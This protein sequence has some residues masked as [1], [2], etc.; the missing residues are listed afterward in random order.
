MLK[1]LRTTFIAVLFA[2]PLIGY[3]LPTFGQTDPQSQVFVIFF[4]ADGAEVDANGRG[5]IQTATAAWR[6]QHG[7]GGIWVIGYTDRSLSSD[8][9]QQLSERRASKVAS[10]FVNSGVPETS[11]FV[12]GRGE[13]EPRVPTP[14]GVREPQNQRVELII[15]SEKQARAFRLQGGQQ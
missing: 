12:E 6:R 3:G 13:N 10:A 1:F 4:N 5:L 15:L 2:I 8:E 9:S 7:K 14:P 11:L